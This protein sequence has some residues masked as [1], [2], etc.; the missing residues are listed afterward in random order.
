M[1]HHTLIACGLCDSPELVI[2]PARRPYSC[3]AM[4][5]FWPRTSSTTGPFSRRT[6]TDKWQSAQPPDTRLWQISRG[7]QATVATQINRLRLQKPSNP[8]Q[9]W[10]IGAKY[11]QWF[12]P[13]S[14][15]P[16]SK[17]RPWICARVGFDPATN[18][19]NQVQLLLCRTLFVPVVRP[20]FINLLQFNTWKW[21]VNHILCI[22][23]GFVETSLYSLNTGNSQTFIF[24]AE[25]QLRLFP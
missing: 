20:E 1:S 2:S 25:L 16:Y 11:Y 24:V 6:P 19:Q 4:D 7:F 18:D 22:W 15:D 14:D 3:L 17:W 8:S 5:H 9:I 10:C 12:L 23:K 21:S 13:R